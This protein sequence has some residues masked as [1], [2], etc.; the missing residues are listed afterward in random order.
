MSIVGPGV[1]LKMLWI[2]TTPE[3]LNDLDTYAEV[4]EMINQVNGIA[5]WGVLSAAT[6]REKREGSYG[7][8]VAVVLNNI[9]VAI[10]SL[11]LVV[12]INGYIY[13]TNITYYYSFHE[14]GMEFYFGAL[15]DVLVSEGYSIYWVVLYN[16][17]SLLTR[18]ARFFRE[19]FN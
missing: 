7:L 8:A 15:T 19:S 5:V 4:M 3:A 11:L 18:V 1:V 16:I 10:L 12:S 2:T 6:V 14:T 9:A 17:P 13:S